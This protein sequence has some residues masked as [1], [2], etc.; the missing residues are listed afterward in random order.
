M[1]MEGREYLHDEASTGLGDHGGP[2]EVECETETLVEVERVDRRGPLHGRF[3]AAYNWVRASPP[4]STF[5]GE[6]TASKLAMMERMILARDPRCSVLCGAVLIV[7]LASAV[8]AQ[9]QTWIRQFGSIYDDQSLGAAADGS[10]G[11]YLCGVTYG[12]FA[13]TTSSEANAWLA[14]F[15]GVGGQSWVREFGSNLR[16]DDATAA[17]PDASGGVFICGTTTGNYA[18]PNGGGRD[19]WLARF[20]GAG[21]Q[22]WIRQFSTDALDFATALASDGAGGV[23]A[24]G[25]TLGSLVLTNVGS[26]D[27][28]LARFDAAGGPT[29]ML[30]FGSDNVDLSNAI[31]PDGAGGAFV[32]GNSGGNLGGPNAGSD[33]AWL[34]RFDGAGIQLWIRQFGT[35]GMDLVRAAAP[36][37]AGG[38]FVTGSTTGSLGGTSAGAEDAWLARFDGAGHRIWI[39]QI[40]SNV[41]DYA[42]SLA[43]SGSGGVYVGGFTRGDLAGPSAGG[44]DQWFALYDG[45]GNQ[46]WRRQSGTNRNDW[47]WASVPDGA[48]GVFVAGESEGPLGGPSAGESDA[49]LAR[50][51]SGLITRYCTPATLNST[52]RPGS[53]SAMGDLVLAAND[54]T[55]EASRLPQ[56]CF[57]LFLTSRTQGLVA[58]PG[59]SQGDLCLG[60]AIGRYVGPGQIKNSGTQGSF[61]LL[62]DLSAMPQPSG[63][64][65]AQPGDTWHFQAWHRDANPGPTSNFT[66]AVSVTLL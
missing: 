10:G 56:S 57:G 54:L 44:R 17:A 28:W 2:P 5:D 32:S 38:V 31:A 66:D 47:A 41:S 40:G 1:A 13:G 37:G 43:P 51:G 45:V 65:A 50:Y 60:S 62:L 25:S 58:N 18:G 53:L 7:A 4:R 48:G 22:S 19:A 3:W 21:N 59:A 15:D 24:T 55:L 27:I 49:W 64:V 36:D 52:G 35:P 29:W 23:Y 33:D 9:Q 46:I 20:D 14:R 34:A 30:Q 16:Y 8:G 6:H 61:H 12:S 39:V 26:Y 11:I 42:T 63:S